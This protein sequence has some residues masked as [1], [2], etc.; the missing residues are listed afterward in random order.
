MI[1]SSSSLERRERR[2]CEL[3]L[4]LQKLVQIRLPGH[5]IRL[6]VMRDVIDPM[7]VYELLCQ[8][9]RCVGS[10][11]VDPSAV[12]D[13][14]AS[15]GV[16]ESWEGFVGFAEVVGADSDDEVDG[17]EA[18]FCLAHLEGVSER[19]EAEEKEVREGGRRWESR[20]RG[21]RDGPVVEEVVNT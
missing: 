14:F 3:T 10:D 5:G 11:L 7:L 16:G 17:G 1:S 12:L 21:G 2:E 8:L 6:L 15:F 19:R 20:G 4:L 9:P 18:E 13:G